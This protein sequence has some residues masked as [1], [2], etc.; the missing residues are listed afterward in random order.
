MMKETETIQIGETTYQVASDS[1][2]AASLQY[3]IMRLIQNEIEKESN[4]I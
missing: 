4:A 2:G 1:S 3:L